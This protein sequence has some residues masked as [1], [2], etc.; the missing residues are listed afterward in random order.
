M[1]V[2]TQSRP[3]MPR[4]WILAAGIGIL[5]IQMAVPGYMISDR[6]ALL[7][8]GREITIKTVPIDPR[9]LFRGDYVILRYD[10]SRIDLAG[11]DAPEDIREGERLNA[12]ITPAGEGEWKAVSLSRDWPQAVANSDAVLTGHVASVYGASGSR[13]AR[14]R[15]GIES[16][17]VP[18]GEGKKLEDMVRERALSVIVAVGED[19]RAA[20]KGLVMDG[21]RIYDE[22]LF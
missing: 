8:N 21:Q 16:Y 17:F 1:S 4:W 20:I 14:M 19:G 5:L 6:A 2:A 13:T 11:F 9:S 10:I 18:E 12:V 15:Y 3:A 22:P 7:K